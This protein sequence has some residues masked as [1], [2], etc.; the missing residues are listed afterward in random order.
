MNE[1]R[2][3]D[4]NEQD[5]PLK[6]NDLIYVEIADNSLPPEFTSK[7]MTVKQLMKNT[8]FSVTIEDVDLLTIGE[9]TLI[10][11]T[12]DLKLIAV[13]SPDIR[14]KS[15]AGSVGTEAEV[16]IGLSGTADEISSTT[17]I[18]GALLVDELHYFLAPMKPVVVDLSVKNLVAEVVTAADTATELTADITVYF[19]VVD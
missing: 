10:P 16:T 8:V 11:A 7:K 14:I 17:T 9:N 13:G 3:P 12:D 4:L 2:L 1:T 5:E 19:R 18:P 6:L 15:K